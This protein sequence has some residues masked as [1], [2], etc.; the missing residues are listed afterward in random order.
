MQFQVKQ[1]LGLQAHTLSE[2]FSSSSDLLGRHPVRNGLRV[3]TDV[4]I[5]NT[6]GRKTNVKVN[7]VQ[8]KCFLKELKQHDMQ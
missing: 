8:K 3:D 1:S 2:N 5:V 7:L 4:S 6:H